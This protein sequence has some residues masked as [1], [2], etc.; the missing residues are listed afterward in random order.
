M[1]RC[2]ER[3]AM[4]PVWTRYSYD[5][6]NGAVIYSTAGERRSRSSPSPFK[7]VLVL[8]RVARVRV[9]VYSSETAEWSKVASRNIG[10]RGGEV[11]TERCVV[12]GNTLYQPLLRWHTLSFDLESRRFNVIPHPEE[13]LWRDDRRSMI[14]KLDN[15]VLGLVATNS[16]RLKLDLYV[17][18]DQDWEMRRTL[19]L[20][21]LQPL[22]SRVNNI[23]DIKLIGACDHANVVFLW[24]RHGAFSLNVDSMEL[25]G[26]AYDQNM[27]PGTLYPYE[28]FFAVG[29]GPI[30]KFM[31]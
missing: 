18:E 21:T 9:A 29:H 8:W 31:G 16:F 14:V 23:R 2:R 15:S 25:K 30:T 4:P 1:T 26:L 24:T 12:V 5:K 7:V 22:S 20:D 17:W 11:L 28:S 19:Q 6:I 10:M 27:T 13:L 3:I